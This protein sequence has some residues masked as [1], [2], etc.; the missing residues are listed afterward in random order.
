MLGCMQAL[1]SNDAALE[2]LVGL[3]K[4]ALVTIVARL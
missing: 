4:H 1:L 2:V 3:Q